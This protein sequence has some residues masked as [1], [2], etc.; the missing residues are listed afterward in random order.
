MTAM[1]KT[2]LDTYPLYIYCFGWTFMNAAFT[3][4]LLLLLLSLLLMMMMMMVMMI[5][6]MTVMMMMMMIG[7]GEIP[8]LSNNTFLSL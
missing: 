5:I 1:I 8:F 2:A 7:G 6:M 4:L 3:M